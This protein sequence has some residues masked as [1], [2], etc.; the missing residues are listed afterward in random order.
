MSPSAVSDPHVLSSGKVWVPLENNPS[1]MTKLAHRLG[2]SDDLEFVDVYS[3]T[4]DSLMAMVP[5]PVYAILWLFPITK[6]SEEA[7]A[8]EDAGM[9]LYDGSGAN[10]PVL[11]FRQTVGHACGLM[12]MLHCIINGEAAAHITPG[13]ELDKLVDKAIP[14]KPDARAQQVYDSEF[15]EIAHAEAAHGGDSNVPLP[16]DPVPYGFTAFVKGKDGHLWELEGRRK[17]PVDR[18]LLGP[19]EDILSERVLGLSVYPYIN[20]EKVDESR[21]SCTALVTADK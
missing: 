14:A 7:L 2:L 12:G 1:V 9:A 5:R 17:G 6:N 4:E 18:G 15:L 3:V 21:F 11:W 10:E 13:S 19:D 20:R 16:S 8:E